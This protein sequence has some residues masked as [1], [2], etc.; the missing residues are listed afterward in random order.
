MGLKSESSGIECI[1]SDVHLG[2][3]AASCLVLMGG[4]QP[5]SDLALTWGVN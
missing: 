5:H 1:L 2:T 4:G 3:W